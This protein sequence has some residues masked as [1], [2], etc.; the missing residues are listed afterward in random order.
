MSFPFNSLY[1]R[2]KALLMDKRVEALILVIQTDELLRTGLP[3][4]RITTAGSGLKKSRSQG[5]FES[6]LALL[7]RHTIHA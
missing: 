6:L 7:R 5:T 1:Q 3:V 4:G 2:C